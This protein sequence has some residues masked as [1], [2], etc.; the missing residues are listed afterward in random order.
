MIIKI[1]LHKN[2]KQLKEGEKKSTD[3]F[4]FKNIISKTKTH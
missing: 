1:Y 3:R 4:S 2:I